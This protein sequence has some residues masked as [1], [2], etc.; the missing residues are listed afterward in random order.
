[1]LRR[2]H[3]FQ[4]CGEADRWSRGWSP[5]DSGRARSRETLRH[6]IEVWRLA[7]RRDRHAARAAMRAL[8]PCPVAS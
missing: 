5:R 4:P 3:L 1:V 7:E 2:A 6:A 8:T